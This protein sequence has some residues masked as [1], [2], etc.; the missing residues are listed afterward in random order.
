MS[1]RVIIEKKAEK[2]IRKQAPDVQERLLRAIYGLPLHGDIKRLQGNGDLYRL[3]VGS[4]R[5][6]YAVDGGKLV[7]CVID[8]GN[9]GQIY[10]GY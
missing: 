10:N 6:I 9:R 2:F 4:Y 3:R 7:V 1:Y 8:V 5:I